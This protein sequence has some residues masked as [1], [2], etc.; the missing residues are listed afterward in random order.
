MRSQ[1]SSK[2]EEDIPEGQHFRGRSWSVFPVVL[3]VDFNMCIFECERISC[4]TQLYETERHTGYG[5]PG[6]AF[7][8]IYA[9]AQHHMVTAVVYWHVLHGG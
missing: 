9:G 8:P 7:P 5:R 6:A 1:L 4:H 3:G 2:N